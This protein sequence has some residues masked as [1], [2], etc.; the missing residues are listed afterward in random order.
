MKPPPATSRSLSVN[1]TAEARNQNQS[2]LTFPNASAMLLALLLSTACWTDFRARRISNKLVLI[3]ML[4]GVVLHIFIPKGA[5]LFTVSA[6]SLGVMNALYG[7]AAGFAFLIPL[8]L[9]R[10]M[11][12]GDVKLM[13]MVGTFLGPASVLSA[14]LMTFLAGGILAITVALWKGVF[15]RTIANMHLITKYTMTNA[16]SGHR[17]PIGA[18]SSSTAKL[19][20]A[21][22]IATGTVLQIMLARSGH[23]IFS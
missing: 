4:T 6:G 17:P 13:A 19:P 5:G 10:A 11:G 18:L 8:Y 22:A 21:L 20:Y 3:G 9:L 23:A 15:R 12:A 2:Y 14:V 7:C 16:M 1:S